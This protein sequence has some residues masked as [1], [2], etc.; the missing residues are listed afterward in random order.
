MERP[1]GFWIRFL[2]YVIDQI[3][4]GIPIFIIQFI[5]TFLFAAGA[6]AADPLMTENQFTISFVSDIRRH[7]DS[8]D[9]YC[10]QHLIFQ[11]AHSLKD[12]G[13]TGKSIAR[14]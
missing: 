9:L 1:A 4:I 5:I 3:I 7:P 12:A 10:D 14:P 6:A 8:S 13:D 11:P 2:A